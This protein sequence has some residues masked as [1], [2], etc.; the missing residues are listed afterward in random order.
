MNPWRPVSMAW[1]SVGDG[2]IYL[3]EEHD[4]LEGPFTATL[5]VEKHWH[6]SDDYSL[7]VVADATGR[8]RYENTSEVSVREVADFWNERLAF[9]LM[10]RDTEADPLKPLHYWYKERYGK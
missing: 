2:K 4:Y 1:K 3:P 7:W 6:S 5:F 9:L 8:I 10:V